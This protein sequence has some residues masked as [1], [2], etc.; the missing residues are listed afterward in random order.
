[1]TDGIGVN[2]AGFLK[3]A[4]GLGEA[5]RL[6]VAALQEA[7]VPVRTTTV[8]VPLPETEGAVPKQAEFHAPSLNGDQPFN[9]ICVNA[10]ELPSFY[11]DVGPAFFQGKRSIGVY[12]WEVDRVP[13]AWSWAFDVVDEIW[14]YSTYVADILRRAA[15]SAPVARVPLPVREPSPAGPKPDLGLPDKFTFLFL[16]DFYS[17]LQRKNPL[18]LIE[19]FKRAFKPGRGRSCSSR[20]S[21]ATTSRSASSSC[22]PRRP[23]TRTCTWS[24]ATSRPRTATR[25]WP[26]ATA[27]SRSTAPRASA[28]RWPRRWPSASRSSPQAS[29]A[30][31]TS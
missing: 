17:T 21:T 15:P 22:R 29:A 11:E 4:L 28:S 3:G 16:F 27:T 18:G 14:T 23:S 13:S 10:P 1:M 8:E 2:V 9:L 26:A 5:A 20:A 19:A 6:Y 7:G 31:P 24:T 25:S 30:T 12:A